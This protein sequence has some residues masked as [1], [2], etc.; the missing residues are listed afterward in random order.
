MHRRA[1]ADHLTPET[2]PAAARVA[3]A[4]RRRPARHG[5]AAI[6]LLAEQ[7]PEYAAD[8]APRIA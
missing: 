7:R 6:P 8:Q 3:A 4:P 2:P 5:P 1:W